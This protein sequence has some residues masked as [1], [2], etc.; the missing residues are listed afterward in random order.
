MTIKK[1]LP[2]QNFIVVWLF[3]A[4]TFGFYYSYWFYR[5]GK[6]LNKLKTKRKVGIIA[7][8]FIIILAL[9]R[10]LSIFAPEG[11]VTGAGMIYSIPVIYLSFS[12][13]DLLEENYK[14]DFSWFLTLFFGPIYLQY[15]MD[16]MKIHQVVR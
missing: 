3:N 10:L 6:E 4:I 16:Q 14:V 13:K 8:S 12:V 7:I 9:Y 2:K 15:K 5:V 11:T 1:E